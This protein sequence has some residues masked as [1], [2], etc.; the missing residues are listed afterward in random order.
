[1]L[2]EG[3][4]LPTV[5]GVED[6]RTML[7]DHPIDVMILATDLSVAREFYGDRIGLGVLI[8]PAVSRSRNTTLQDSRPSTA[9]PTSALPWPRGSSIRTATRIGL[10][11]FK[12]AGAS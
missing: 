5:L 3:T 4:P 12:D 9:S 8:A 11:Q 1:V 2:L 7:A 10:L 6:P